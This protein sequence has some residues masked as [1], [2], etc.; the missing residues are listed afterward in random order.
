MSR[1]ESVTEWSRWPSD[2]RGGRNQVTWQFTP[3]RT[4]NSMTVI[5]LQWTSGLDPV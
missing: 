3:H 2:Q 5:P 4:V 1:V